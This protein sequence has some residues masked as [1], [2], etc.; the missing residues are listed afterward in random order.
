MTTQ[1][2]ATQEQMHQGKAA[3]LLE[4]KSTSGVRST[5]SVLYF[6]CHHDGLTL[7]HLQFYK[8][9]KKSMRVLER[10]KEANWVKLG[11]RRKP[12][13]W[14]FQKQG[15]SLIYSSS[16]VLSL[17]SISAGSS[18]WAPEA[19][20]VCREC[21]MDIASKGKIGKSDRCMILQAIF[22]CLEFI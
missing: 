1:E 5:F 9:R 14:V 12:F 11:S 17:G 2:V 7:F 10:T 18:R 4:M 16:E 21:C 19:L 8:N 15:D 20:C 6:C 3:V 22:C 13:T